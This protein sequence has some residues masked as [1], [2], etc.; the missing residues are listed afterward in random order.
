MNTFLYLWGADS[1]LSQLDKISKNKTVYYHMTI[2]GLVYKSS[3]VEVR[4]ADTI[5]VE[6]SGFI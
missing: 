1:V 3:R 5:E 6:C 4:S 2:R